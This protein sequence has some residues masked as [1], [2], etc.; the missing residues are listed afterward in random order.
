MAQSKTSSGKRF[1]EDFK[2]SIPSYCLKHRLKD[3]GQSFTDF[4]EKSDSNFSWNNECDFFIFDDIHRL[5]FAIENKTTKFKTMNWENEEEYKHNKE[6]GKKSTK[7][8]KWHQI[9]SLINFSA[10]NYVIPCL[11]LNF[12]DNDDKNQR[13]YFIHI[14]SFV[15]MINSVSKKSFDEIDLIQNNAVRIQGQIKRTR[16]TW[17]IDQFL[18]KYSLNYSN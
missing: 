18:N 9:K 8:I 2:K 1:E 10:F 3:S 16:Y 13:T 4:T 12:R 14:N 11:V 15:K 5:F 7:L 6:L 17:D